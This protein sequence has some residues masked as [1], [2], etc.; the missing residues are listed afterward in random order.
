MRLVGKISVFWNGCSFLVII[1]KFQQERDVCDSFET[2]PAGKK[3]KNYGFAKRGTLD[4]RPTIQVDS[5]SRILA[6]KMNSPRELFECKQKP[7]GGG[8]GKT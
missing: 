5:E 3:R 7:G 1:S 4:L 2:G 8:H 6:E